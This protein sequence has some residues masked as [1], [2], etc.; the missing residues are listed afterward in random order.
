M[1][2]LRGAAL[3]DVPAFGGE[4]ERG[5]SERLLRVAARLTLMGARTSADLLRREEQ[6]ITR[7]RRVERALRRPGT[8]GSAR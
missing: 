1:P 5:G 3:L 6:A 4:P 2:G 8:A 7:L